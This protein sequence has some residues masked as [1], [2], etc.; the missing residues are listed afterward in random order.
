MCWFI[1]FF[2]FLMIR[3][4][5]RSTLFPYTTLFRSRWLSH[6]P[7]AARP[8]T[9]GS[10]HGTLAHRGQAPSCT[11]LLSRPGLTTSVD[12]ARAVHRVTLVFFVTIGRRLNGAAD[13]VEVDRALLQQHHQLLLQ[14]PVGLRQPGQR[15]QS[16]QLERAEV[17]RAG[18]GRRAV[19]HVGVLFP[20]HAALTQR[21]DSRLDLFL[22]GCHRASRNAVSIYRLCRP[23]RR[24]SSTGSPA[25]RLSA[26][27]RLSAIRP[28]TVCSP[29]R[30]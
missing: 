17:E 13:G 5:P 11:L 21:I 27:I 3:R 1:F 26:P 19:H 4:P 16:R 8:R 22:A 30:R 9:S 14:Q 18:G 7:S 28:S 20:L 24:A 15:G 6:V 29:A 23:R 2:F 25:S 10:A 12:A